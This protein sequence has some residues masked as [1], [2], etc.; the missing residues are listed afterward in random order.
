MVAPIENDTL[1]SGPEVA[2][3]PVVADTIVSDTDSGSDQKAI[4]YGLVLD[5]DPPKPAATLRDSQNVVSFILGGVFILFL[6]IALRFRT[7]VKYAGAIFRSLIETRTRHNVFD[8]TVRETSLLLM[9]NLLWCCCVGIIAD[10]A[11]G[12]GKAALSP[13]SVNGIGIVAWMIAALAY[14]LFMGLAYVSV[15]WVFSD[16]SHAKVWVKGFGASQ[17]LMVFPLFV[18]ALVAIC[19]PFD[20]EGVGIAGIICFIGARLIFIWKGYKIFFSQFSSWVLFLCYL[21]SLEIVPLLLTYRI[22]CLLGEV[23]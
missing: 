15:G 12:W 20:G 19:R 8:E 2:L 6:V 17:A 16:K 21:C 13:G 5:A 18:V 9:L 4:S 3:S 10:T 11:V 7:N 23:L 1:I 22:G 14:S